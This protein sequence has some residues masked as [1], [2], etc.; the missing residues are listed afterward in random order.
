MSGYL[1]YPLRTGSRGSRTRELY[2]SF[3]STRE[4]QIFVFPGFIGWC[5]FGMVLYCQL[6]GVNIDYGASIHT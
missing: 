6:R 4:L 3:G 2:E 5:G 1:V